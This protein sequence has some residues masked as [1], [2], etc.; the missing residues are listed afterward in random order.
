ML[1]WKSFTKTMH[2]LNWNHFVNLNDVQAH[3]KLVLLYKIDKRKFSLLGFLCGRIVLFLYILIAGAKSSWCFMRI[4]N[5]KV[6]S[7]AYY[8]FFMFLAIWNRYVHVHRGGFGDKYSVLLSHLYF[9]LFHS[10]LFH[11]QAEFRKN[12]RERKRERE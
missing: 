6:Q 8:I 5:L 3:E 1:E 10:P 12:F 11:I 7:Q 9:N 4:T 2:F